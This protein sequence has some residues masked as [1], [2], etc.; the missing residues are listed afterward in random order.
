MNKNKTIEQVIGN[1]LCTG[2]GTC[3]G[4]CPQNAIEM[5]IDYEKGI[6][7]P[8]LDRKK[9]NECEI[10]FKV[11]PGHGIEFNALNREIFGRE[12]EDILLGN[13]H[14]FYTGYAFD[15]EIRYHSASGGLVTALLIFALEEGLIDGALVSRMT[16][17]NPLEPQPFI[18]R[19]REDIIS[20]ARSIYCPVPA[21]IALKEI[22]QVGEHERF[23]VVGLPCHLHGLRKAEIL[24]NSLKKKIAFHFGLFCNHVPTF[25]ATDYI[26]HKVKIRRDDVKR[27]DYRGEGWPGRMSITL[28]NK[29]INLP[30]NDYWGS[31]FGSFFKPNRC[32][33]CVDMVSELSDISFGDAWI[34]EYSIDPMGTSIIISRSKTGERLLQNA[35]DKQAISLEPIIRDKVIWS[36]RQVIK[37]K[38]SVPARFFL[39]RR[40]SKKVPEYKTTFLKPRVTAYFSGLSCYF[41]TYLGKRHFLWRCLWS[42]S[43]WSSISRIIVLRIIKSLGLYRIVARIVRGF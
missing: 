32:T 6:Y 21:N 35:L 7:L 30:L 40:M 10:C 9:C 23:A 33:L 36:T 24:H 15:N 13:Y 25:Q 17:E 14:N 26:L 4:T 2:C 22:L 3:S 34:G 18:A 27:L 11:C 31:G 8:K 16:E 43:R 19:T 28:K 42:L 39:L 20:A 12:A 37:F 38:K 41:Y 1:K 29:V 5:V